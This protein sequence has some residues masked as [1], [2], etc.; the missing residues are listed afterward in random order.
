MKRNR[1]FR[2][3]P[4][5]ELQTL[6]QEFSREI[7]DMRNEKAIARKLDRPH[8]LR[9]KIKDRARLLTFITQRGSA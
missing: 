2:D 3:L 1:R 7:F 6:Y 9:E 8:L 4:I 5:G